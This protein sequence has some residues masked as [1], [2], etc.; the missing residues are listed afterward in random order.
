MGMANDRPPITPDLK[1]GALLDAYPELEDVLIEIAPA[2]RKLRNPVLRRTVA[3]LTSLRQAA[4]VGGVS[5]GAMIGRLRKAA[6]QEDVPVDDDP[7]PAEEPAA[8][9]A[10]LDACEQIETFDARVEIEGGGHPL[11]TVMSAIG[12]LRPGH[13]F[14]IVTPFVPAPMIDKV[15]E[16]GF[17]AWTEH[18]G[19]EHFV[20]Y[21]AHRS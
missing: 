4:T 21:F 16:R 10:W 14:A 8:R 17:D 7:D 9:P 5:L 2:F 6:G 18:K 13:A 11:P 15:V 1:V 12:Q 20:T 19:E 3:R